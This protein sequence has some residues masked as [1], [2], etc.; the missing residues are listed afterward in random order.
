M[1]MFVIFLIGIFIGTIIGSLTNE[2]GDYWI[3]KYYGL[4]PIPPKIIKTEH[5]IIILQENC[6][7]DIA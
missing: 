6:N 4:P 1:I 2:N 7:V 5:E 3:R